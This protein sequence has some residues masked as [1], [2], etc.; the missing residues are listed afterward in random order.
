MKSADGAL[1]AVAPTVV[2]G[3]ND[4]ENRAAI[5]GRSQDQY[6]DQAFDPDGF[7]LRALRQAGE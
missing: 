6:I 7:S 1:S 4:K 3:V 5:G 2:V